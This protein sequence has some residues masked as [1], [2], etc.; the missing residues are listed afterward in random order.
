MKSILRIPKTNYKLVNID[1]LFKKSHKKYNTYIHENNVTNKSAQ[2][3]LFYHTY[4]LDIC[5]SIIKNNNTFSPV[6]LLSNSSKALDKEERKLYDKFLKILPVL[7][8]STDT[9]YEEFEK[10]LQDIG[11]IEEVL[12]AISLSHQKN[13]K[14]TFYFSKI[15]KFCERYELTFLDKKFFSNIKNKMSL[16]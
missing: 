9:P 12:S 14:K 6:L 1:Q 4:I 15:Q 2:K 8:Y 16:I 3:K 10:D 5:E 13:S 11:M 7:N